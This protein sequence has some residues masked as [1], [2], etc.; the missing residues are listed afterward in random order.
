MVTLVNPTPPNP[1]EGGSFSITASEGSPD[2]EFRWKVDDQPVHTV[3]QSSATLSISLP[4]GCAGDKLF[5]SV[6]DGGS[7]SDDK[8]YNIISH[9]GQG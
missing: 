9:G 4:T 1:A 6:T 2:Y 7:D 5:V 3:E 8:D